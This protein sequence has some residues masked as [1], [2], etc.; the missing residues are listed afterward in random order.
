[1]NMFYIGLE[2]PVN[3]AVD[4]VKAKNLVVEINGG[5]LKGE[6]GSYVFIPDGSA[7]LAVLKVGKKSKK[8]IKWIDSAEY[9]VRRV[10]KPEVLFGTKTGGKMSVGE[11]MAVRQI[12]AGI[13]EGF[14]FEGIKYTVTSYQIMIISDDIFYTETVKG[15]LISSSTR[16]IFQSLQ[17]SG[18]IIIN[19]V[20]AKSRNNIIKLKGISLKVRGT[21]TDFDCYSVILS[22]QYIDK[23]NNIIPEII[24]ISTEKPEDLDFDENY[25]KNGLWQLKNKDLLLYEY[26]Y[27]KDTLLWSKQ[28]YENGKLKTNKT[29][30]RNNSTCSYI[31]YYKNGSVF[32]KG[33]FLLAENFET[34]VD[35]SCENKYFFNT[36]FICDLAEIN[37]C[38]FGKWEV[39]NKNGSL[40][41]VGNMDTTYTNSYYIVDKIFI[42]DPN[43]PYKNL[44]DDEEATAFSVRQGLWKFYD[45]KGEL[46]RQTFYDNGHIKE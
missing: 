12:N 28:Y 36:Y 32:R 40:S 9:R 18:I 11:L 27:K 46:L 16:K 38:L 31:D 15:N 24:N 30:N 17:N 3:V 35:D 7:R 33:N 4:G 25:K 20:E 13:G 5:E 37:E 14:A 45:D 19:N 42:S 43:D 39:F 29:Y 41:A 8:G 22:G 6:N 26:F 21:L 10:P 23:N 1:M 34:I 44:Y 2:N